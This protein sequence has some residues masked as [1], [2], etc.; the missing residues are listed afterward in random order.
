MRRSIRTGIMVT[1]LGLLPLVADADTP[2]QHCGPGAHWIHTTPW[3][4]AGEDNLPETGAVIGID[5]SGDCIEDTSL[6]LYGPTTIL[7]SGPQDD[8]VYFPGTR[9]IDGHRDVLDTEIVSLNLTGGGATLIAGAG[10]GDIPLAA[11][12]GAIA[13]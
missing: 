1:C 11:S 2:C 12:W 10:Q 13:E 4:P 9:P 6:V 8:S 7:R 3:C 5:L